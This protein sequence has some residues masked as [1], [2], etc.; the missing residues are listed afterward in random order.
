MKK[1]AAA[2]ALQKLPTVFSKEKGGEK[3]EIW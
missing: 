1:D 3:V 2:Q